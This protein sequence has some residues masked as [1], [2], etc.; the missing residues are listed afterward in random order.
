[1]QEALAFARRTD[2]L[3]FTPQAEKLWCRVYP[4]L[5][6]D[7]P[8][9]LGAITARAEPQ[10]LRIAMVYALLDRSRFIAKKHLRAA[11]AVWR[12]CEDS[13]R[14]IFG[15]AFGDPVV[16][17]ILRQLRDSPEGLTRN[18]IREMFSRNKS[19]GEITRA[20]GVLEQHGLIHC[21]QEETGGR[22]AE[23]WFATQ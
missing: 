20:L 18:D 12:Y 9:L 19:E 16:D 10:V 15:D 22:P 21:E 23:R 8:G 17:T 2:E 5:S 14:C 4:K 13:A 7:I 11:L 1:L 6:A 3:R